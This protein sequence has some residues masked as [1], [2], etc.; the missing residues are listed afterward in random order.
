MTDSDSCGLGLLIWVVPY[1]PVP[2]T[3]L[4]PGIHGIWHFPRPK[5]LICAGRFGDL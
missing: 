4:D 1:K 5:P 2:L 3:P